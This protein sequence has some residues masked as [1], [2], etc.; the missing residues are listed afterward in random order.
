MTGLVV[1][2]NSVPED[3]AALRQALYDF[4]FAETGFVDG[5]DLC[6][7]VKD[8]SG[9]LV[10]G[11]DGFTWGGY[12]RIEF[13]WVSPAAR[14]SGMG[15]ALAQAA[16]DEARRRKCRTVVVSTHTFQAPDFYRSLGFVEVGR[17]SGTP[18]GFD[19]VLYQLHL[20]NAEQ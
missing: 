2:D 6:C 11:I 8:E 20:G 12:A 16:I 5:R 15:R 10:A 4:N 19:E 14:G 7:F 18:E 13:L 17:T 9:A 1:G 3:A